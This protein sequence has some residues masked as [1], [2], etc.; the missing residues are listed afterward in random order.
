MTPIQLPVRAKDIPDVIFRD[1]LAR[2]HGYVELLERKALGLSS[3][4]R[5]QI[6]K[7]CTWNRSWCPIE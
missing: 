2:V 5:R 4:T 6:L 1:V 7:G 3:Q